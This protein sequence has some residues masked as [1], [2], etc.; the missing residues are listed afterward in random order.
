MEDRTTVLLMG[1]RKILI[2]L[3]ATLEDYLGV[4]Y[5][6]SALYKRRTKR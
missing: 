3:V 2:E 5:D 6:T 1:L 4:A